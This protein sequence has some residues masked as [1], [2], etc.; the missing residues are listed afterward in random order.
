MVEVFSDW[1]R[2]GAMLRIEIALAQAQGLSRLAASL[3]GIVPD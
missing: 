3:E 1:S 2:I